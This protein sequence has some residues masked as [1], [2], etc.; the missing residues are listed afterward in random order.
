MDSLLLKIVTILRK[1][2]ISIKG[3]IRPFSSIKCI[4]LF[5]RWTMQANCQLR[6]CNISKRRLEREMLKK[7]PWIRLD[8]FRDDSD[9]PLPLWDHFLNPNQTKNFTE[10]SSIVTH[11]IIQNI[12]QSVGGWIV[13]FMN[14]IS[15]TRFAYKHTS[16]YLWISTGRMSHLFGKY[17]P[18]KSAVLQVPLENR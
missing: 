7:S 3:K 18:R 11:W 1:T 14:E 17:L 4:F 13:S 15:A 2:V 8:I 12:V 10:N 6:D 9:P 16:E 5:I